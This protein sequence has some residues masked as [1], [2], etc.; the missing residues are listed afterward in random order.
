V[1]KK[2]LMAVRRLLV[3]RIVS[4]RAMPMG[5]RGDRWLKMKRPA[6]SKIKGRKTNKSMGPATRIITITTLTIIL[7]P[8]GMF[9]FRRSSSLFRS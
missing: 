4:G 5:E 7:G 8:G 1:E 6:S 2:K 9:I 3:L